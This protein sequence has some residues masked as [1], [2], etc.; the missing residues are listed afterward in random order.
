MQFA[1]RLQHVAQS[2]ISEIS[3]LA[4]DHN[5]LNLAS[6]LPDWDAP[7]ELIEAAIEALRSGH[8]QYGATWGSPGLR[9]AVAEKYRHWYGL[10]VDPDRHVTITVGVTEALTGA[11][12]ALI[13]PGD[14]VIIVEPAY[15]N[16]WPAVLFAGGEAIYV[17]LEPPNFRLDLD[18]LVAAFEGGAKAIILNTPHNPTGRVLTRSELEV[19][20]ELCQRYDALCLTDEIYEH[21][22]YDGRQHLPIATLPGMAERTMTF[23][24]LGKTYSVTGWRI[25]W[26]VGPGSL[27]DALRKVHDYL[28]ICAPT[29]LQEAAIV[30]FNFPDSYYTDLIQ[31]YARKRSQMMDILT[32]CGFHTVNPEGAYY[33]MADFTGLGF[34]GDDFTFARFITEQIGVAA[35]PGSSFYHDPTLGRSMV[36]FA[37]P[38]RDETLDEVG[39]RLGRLKSL[40]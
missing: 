38:K 35:V 22:V 3:R 11:I 9:Q 8:N 19:V 34:H 29:P 16:Y 37:F 7:P 13:D 2:A 4:V 36:R 15:E 25:G 24:G 40:I 27:T 32:E 21:I 6:G 26:A 23:S 20:A 12:I 5:A 10:D 28:V 18:R 30:A 33:I 14:R 1:A 39:R 31:L 17:P